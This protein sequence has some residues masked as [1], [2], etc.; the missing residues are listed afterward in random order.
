[1][2]YYSTSDQALRTSLTQAIVHCVAPEG[3]LYMPASWPV[4]PR[5][6][7]NNIDQL[8]LGDIAYVVANSL[9][10]DDVDGAVLKQIVAD[11]INF[12]IPLRRIA[13]DIFVLE[14]FHGPSLS[15]KDVGTRFLAR[16]Y[17]PLQRRPPH[18]RARGHHRQQRRR[19]RQRLPRP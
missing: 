19:H 18:Q 3:G 15:F 12:R 7:F 8:S 14:L 16:L 17:R 4:V 1:M 13:G 9:L 5:A 10:G 11:S 2:Q 6:F